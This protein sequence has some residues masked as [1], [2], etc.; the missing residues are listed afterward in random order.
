MRPEPAGGRSLLRGTLWTSPVRAGP[1]EHRCVGLRSLAGGP[2]PGGLTQHADDLGVL[3]HGAPAGGLHGHTHV[4]RAR[5][6]RR[7]PVVQGQQ[8][9]QGHSRVGPG[10][11]GAGGEL[12]PR[13]GRWPGLRRDAREWGSGG[14]GE[15]PGGAGSRLTRHGHQSSS[16]CPQ[17][18]LCGWS[19]RRTWP[20]AGPPPIVPAPRR[21]GSLSTQPVGR[22]ASTWWLDCLRPY[23]WGQRRWALSC[24]CPRCELRAQPRPVPDLPGA[25]H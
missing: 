2:P 24:R 17:P 6:A 10:R 8:G 20:R 5:E 12:A 3:Q 21:R 11:A 1:P 19:R 4:P 15:D 25:H 23:R 7:H 13:P 22:D 18:L 9:L 14:R 16:G